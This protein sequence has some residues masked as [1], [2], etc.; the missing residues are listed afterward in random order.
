VISEPAFVD[1]C[2]ERLAS[3]AGVHRWLVANVDH[4]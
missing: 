2:T 1:W 3:C 4:G